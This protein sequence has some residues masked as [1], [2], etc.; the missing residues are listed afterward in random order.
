MHPAMAGRSVRCPKCG[1]FLAIPARTASGGTAPEP[2]DAEPGSLAGLVCSV[3]QTPIER[4]EAA[5]LCPECRSPHHRECWDEI[6]GCAIYGCTLMPRSEKPASA[7]QAGRGTEAWGDDKTCPRCGRQIRAAAMK[8]RF[9]HASFASAL[10]MTA[11][12]YYEW[13][14][15]QQQLRPTRSFAIGLFAASLVGIL[16]PVTLIGGL[17]WMRGAKSALQR[18]GGTYQVLAWVGIVLSAIYSAIMVAFVVF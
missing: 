15:G 18:V 17:I 16:A 12:E 6:G 4:D 1:L 11:Q 7:E 14:R 10:P 5:C 8:C 2:L 9:C 3:C 13:V